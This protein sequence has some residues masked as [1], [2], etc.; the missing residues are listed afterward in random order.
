MFQSQGTT[1]VQW[2]DIKQCVT[3]EAGDVSLHL[4]AADCK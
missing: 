3:A 2:H 4:L 1:S